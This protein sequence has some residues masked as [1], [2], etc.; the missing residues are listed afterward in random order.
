[1]KLPVRPW[2]PL[3]T[4]LLCLSVCF[5]ARAGNPGN[6]SD[7]PRADAA[8]K[9]AAATKEMVTIPGPLRGFLRMAGIS[10]EAAPDEV[11]PLLARNVSLHGYENN[12]ETEYLVLLRRYVQFA[13]EL[14]QQADAQG[15]IRVETCDDAERLV[16]VLGY[17]FAEGCGE[18]KA[19]VVTANAERA[20]LTID[21]GFPLTA[22]EDALQKHTPFT[23][24]F[25]AT[26]VPVLFREQDWTTATAWRQKGGANL[27]DVLLHDQD[28]DVLYWALS[29]ND[30]ETRQA[31]RQGRNLRA[32]VPMATALEFYGGQISIHSGRVWVPGGV[33]AEK[34]WQELVG[35]SAGSP[36]E[37]TMHLFSKDRGWLAAY[38]DALSRVSRSEQTHL[39]QGTRLKQLYDVYR[40]AGANSSATRGVFPRNADLL[41]LFSRLQWQPDGSPYIPGDLGVWREILG[42][43]SAP[44]LI[45]D[46]VRN[47]RT[48]DSPEQLLMTLVAC[49]NFSSD[50]GPLQVYL[51]LSAIDTAR[52]PGS[53]LDDGTVRLMAGK[54]TQFHSWYL[55]FAEFPTLND[56]SI[57]QFV[58]AGEAVTGIGNPALR[59]NALG[60]LQANIGLWEILARQQEI[61]SSKMNASWQDTVH[62]FIGVNSAAQLFEAT[63][64]SLRGAL[65][66]TGAE[67]NLS[68]EQ[69]IEV[70]AGPVQK[71][72]AGRRAHAEIADRIRAV[73]DDQRLVSL[74]TLFG[75][76]DGLDQ[77]AHGSAVK[78]Q[79]IPMAGSL[80]EFEMP[81]AIFSAGEKAA[82]A[83]QIYTSRHAELQ[84]RTDLTREIQSAA[85][86]AQLETARGQLTPFL[87]DT[88]VGLNYAYYEP[89]GAQVLHNNPL[90]VRSHD[91][92]GTSILG[93]G[94]IW[95]APEL[96]GIGVTAG[97]GAYLIGSLAN[98]PYALA[99]AEE[100]F[101]APENVQALIWQAAGPAILVDAVEPRW[102]DVTPAELHAAALYQKMGEELLLA[103]P[104]NAQMRG[105]V[106][107]IL[108]DLM[109]P[110]RL[111][112]TERGLLHSEEAAA[113]IPEI[114]PAEKFYLA[115]EYR[116]QYAGDATTW[117]AAGRE[118]DDLERKS[119]A[120]V[121][122][123]RLSKDFGVPHPT[124]EQTNACAI[125]S[126]RPL[127]AYSGEAYGL[128]G[129]SWESSN[130]YWARLADEMGYSPESLNLL[131]PEL[132]RRMIAKIFATDLEDWPAIVRAMEQTGEEFRKGGIHVAAVGTIPQH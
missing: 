28:L 111:E 37:F 60:A 19:Y 97:G 32:L 82:W 67:P 105:R 93:Y 42:E 101:I 106:V 11:L 47:A 69:I 104:D 71:T 50:S 14:R 23:Y 9:A 91:F 10:Q 57:T 44:K 94:R 45:H 62:P 33:D 53:R 120:E 65:V 51:T 63:R 2:T 35:A 115:A 119:P 79:L 40:R 7:Q 90:F 64:N 73:L 8:D 12:A 52:A 21:S 22:L 61:P 16:D 86:P 36:S 81:R 78:D 123:A 13:R 25:P 75:L 131:I 77:L 125:L 1:M 92:S 56:T 89:P 102:W 26:Q 85:S 88:L 114:T 24:Q 87:R 3:L 39:T 41:I 99:T 15:T 31:L 4:A 17:Q 129:E 95:N 58:N 96:V 100:D 5:S 55:A 48:W 126:V 80:R 43:N 128:M 103:S 122:E 112:L 121:S 66:G 98:L 30:E 38:Y 109:S 6:S 20:F 110:R 27:I 46:W 113:M 127:P 108:G 124:L 84:V 74:D 117:G 83:P 107:E 70:L 34:A 68:Q 49:S 59:S 118:L 116:K 29:K 130:L 76:Y 54:F 132:S 72:E 18:K